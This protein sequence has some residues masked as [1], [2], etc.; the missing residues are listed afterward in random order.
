MENKCKDTQIKNPIT[1][2]CVNKFGKI[3]KKLMIMNENI[4][5]KWENNS[6][7][8]D[9]LL[10]SLFHKKDLFIENEL[11]N[12]PLIK[13]DKSDLDDLAM[14]IK[15]ELNKIY[16]IIY[17]RKDNIKTCA[18]LR[19]LLNNFY[20]KLVK[21]FPNK[22]ILDNNDNWTKSQLDVFDLLNL[23]EKI[24]DMKK[25]LIFK[26]GSNKILTDFSYMIPVDLLIN[27]KKIFIKKII[28][29]YHLIN[30]NIKKEIIILKGNKLFLK[31]FRN[32]G[33]FKLETMII[34]SKIL[35]LPKN[36]FNLY[37]T[38]III[39]YGSYQSGHYICLYNLYGSGLWFEYDDLKNKSVYI[40]NLSQ[41]IKN[42]NYI[43]NIVGLIYSK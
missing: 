10:I 39:H 9:S 3:G 16:E 38:S 29:N 42:E 43:S 4:N 12:A 21:S 41:V 2:R 34:P 35:K 14:K 23:L 15:N 11:L 24:F 8:S 25:S 19:K 5:I 1:K 18:N 7:Y 6:C 32:L 22:K 40:G 13:Y 33:N 27:K 26:E 20:K 31:I 37:L 28:P 30:N 17:M 36:S